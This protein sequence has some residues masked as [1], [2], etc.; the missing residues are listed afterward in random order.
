MSD[1][2]DDRGATITSPASPVVLKALLLHGHRLQVAASAV[3]G[4]FGLTADEW[5]ILDALSAAEGLFMSEV[6]ARSLSSGA[7]LTRAVDR[8]VTRSLVYRSPSLVDRRKV[9]VHL[10]DLGRSVHAEMTAELAALDDDLRAALADVEVDAESVVAA[11]T[12]FA[13][14]R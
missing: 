7:S 5:L 3:G 11:L 12:E 2:H 9:H 10:S 8:L 6:S 1:V 4:A 13:D 14:P